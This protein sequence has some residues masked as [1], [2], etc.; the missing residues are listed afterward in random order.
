MIITV[1]TYDNMTLKKNK[2]VIPIGIG[3]NFH[4]KIL[5][6]TIYPTQLSQTV[7]IRPIPYNSWIG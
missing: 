3:M 4:K 6:A 7:L 5:Q 2:L 1:V